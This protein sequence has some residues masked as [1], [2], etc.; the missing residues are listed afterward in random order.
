MPSASIG[1]NSVEDLQSR[2]RQR[3]S[4]GRAADPLDEYERI[5][6]VIAG[7]HQEMHV[8]TARQQQVWMTS[9]VLLTG[10]GSKLGTLQAAVKRKTNRPKGRS[11][12][13]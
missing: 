11:L 13:P 10:S 1:P 3:A 6:A 9:C 2:Q 12:D 4:E 7:T 8:L 5:A